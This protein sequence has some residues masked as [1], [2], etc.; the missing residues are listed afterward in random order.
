MESF[1]FT[2]PSGES[3]KKIRRYLDRRTRYNFA[4]TKGE[5]ADARVLDTFD[6]EIR[7]SGRIL[8]QTGQTLLLINLNS[9][10]IVEQHAGP[11]WSFWTDLD[12][13]PVA[14]GL[15]NVSRLRAFL[16]VSK[17]AVRCDR[18][19]VLDDEGKT[20]VRLH[21]I[22]FLR[23]RKS[24][25]FGLTQSLRGYDRAHADLQ[26]YLLEMGADPVGDVSRIFRKLG[27]KQREYSAKPDISIAHENPIKDSATTIIRTYIDIARCSE[28]GMLADYDTEFLHD[29]RVC[30]RKVRSVL[31]LFKGV[32]GTDQTREL[33]VEFAVLMRQTNSLRDLDVYLL[34]KG[35]YFS[36]VPESSHDGLKIL[37]D[38]MAE[39][40]MDEHKKICRMIKSK[41]YR[42]LG[43]RWIDL[44]SDG[45]NIS[46][47]SRAMESSDRYIGRLILSRYG[48]VCKIARGIDEATADEVVHELR[49]HC[50]KLRYL[51][52]FSLPFF[53]RKKVKALLKPLK[54]LQDNL[55][56]FNDFS[57]QQI[58]LGK[59]MSNQSISPGKSLKVAESIGALTAMLYQLQCRERNLVME[60]FSFFDSEN[61]HASFSKLFR[62]K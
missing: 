58:F 10:H 49:I 22:S 25:R 14:A 13:G 51:M 48:K 46:S 38:I 59:F 45:K 61:V 37:F 33:K 9:G 53:P 30:F 11:S 7:L 35:A 39:K 42:Q 12:S 1:I 2:L 16:V 60:N 31:S 40:R 15:K 20:R 8:L 62:F 26:S 24:L 27:I 54:V 3:I 21:I 23:K 50:K 29:Y 18:G 32:Y 34:E 41:S 5:Y 57:V 28:A 56:R 47:G 6:N 17:L 52:E 55:G 44:F 4:V 43:N 19:L 36:M